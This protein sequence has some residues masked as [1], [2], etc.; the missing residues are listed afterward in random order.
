M[1]EKQILQAE[2][3]R[4]DEAAAAAMAVGDKLFR[5]LFELY[6]FIAE[7]AQLFD[8]RIVHGLKCRTQFEKCQ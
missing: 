2:D 5:G 7:V 3:L 1:S 8:T 4:P 6:G